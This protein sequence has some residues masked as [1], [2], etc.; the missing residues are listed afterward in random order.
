MI[1][2]C[3]RPVWDG[4]AAGSDW[5]CAPRRRCHP[6]GL[7]LC[8]SPLGEKGMVMSIAAAWVVVCL[9]VVAF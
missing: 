8:V 1:L 4:A 2:I 5:L 9:V 6:P 7:A 3:G